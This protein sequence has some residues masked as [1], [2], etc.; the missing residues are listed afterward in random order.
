MRTRGEERIAT[1]GEKNVIGIDA[2][3]DHCAILKIGKRHTAPEIG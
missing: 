3:D 1:A 2:A